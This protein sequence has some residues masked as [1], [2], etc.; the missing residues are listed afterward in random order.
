VIRNRPGTTLVVRVVV[1]GASGNVGTAVLRRLVAEPAVDEVVGVARR[2]PAGAGDPYD[3]V[4][5]HAVDVT[6]PH[7]PARLRDIV[8]GADAVISLVWRLQP[9]WDIEALERVNV[10]GTRAVLDAVLAA[11][12]P[13]FVYASSIGTY[14][15]APDDRPRDESWPA[16]GIATSTYSRQKAAVEEFLDE[17]DPDRLAVLRVRP[18]IVLQPAAAGEIARFFLGPFVPVS[19]LR[20]ALLRV[21]PWPHGLRGQIVHADD[22][23]DAFVR[24][25]LARA[26]GGL[27][28]ATEPLLTRSLVTDLLRAKAFDLPPAL[29]RAL[30]TATW[31]LRLQPTDAGW[32]D[33]ALNAPVLDTGK[34]R[35]LGWSPTRPTDAV[36]REFLA[37]LA[38][39]QGTGSPALAPRTPVSGR[40]ATS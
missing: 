17:V 25:M 2:L 23:A 16:T 14:A 18:A 40:R 32:L 28:V 15:P 20:P 10:G 12:V 33:M 19:L 31:K 37:A 3:S 24:G 5:W 21:L 39:G 38:A 1:V 26:T 8:A 13:Q 27:N 11:G 4:A 7:A 6:A 29:P 22:L 35:A 34:A 30:A 9:S 36:L